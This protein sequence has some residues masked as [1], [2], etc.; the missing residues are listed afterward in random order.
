M[1]DYLNN[2]ISGLR[3]GQKILPSE[4]IGFDGY[5]FGNTY[6]VDPTN[7][8]DL[9]PG[10]TPDKAFATA[11]L[12]ND[13]ITTNNND[14]VYLSGYASHTVT[15]MLT[16]SKNRCHF[17]GTDFDGRKFGQVSKISMG[18]T[19]AATDIGIMKNTG[20]RNSFM[21]IKFSSDNTVAE[22][23]Y[24]VVDGSEYAVYRNCEFYKSTDTDT[25]GSAEFVMNADSI[26]MFNCTFGSTANATSGAII[27]ANVLLTKGLAGTGK[28]TRDGYMEDCL[29]FKKA[30]NVADRF[31]YAA[32]SAD[33]ER[34][35][36]LVRPIFINAVL[37]AADPDQCI[38]AGAN[39][40]DGHILCYYPA[41]IN[42]TK[43]S[44]TT[45]VFVIGAATG[46]TAGLA[47][48]AA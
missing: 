44:T 28:V 1:A 19:T 8:S 13:T 30:G 29:F 35:L 47:T 26:Q 22:S 48:Q 7:G 38:A 45:G 9:N 12:A 5:V 21:G 15:E 11:D 36:T 37:A 6:Y 43:L 27:R 14:A 39:L 3:C 40:I 10:T 18:V 33:I 17:I 25:T 20:V 31:I 34:G 46:A 41:F 42:A 23:L 32:A 24:G 4:I 2:S 16:V